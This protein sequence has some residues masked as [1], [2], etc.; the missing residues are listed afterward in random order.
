MV[1][2]PSTR[3]VL[4][5][6][7]TRIAKCQILLGTRQR[8]LEVVPKCL[9]SPGPLGYGRVRIGEVTSNT[10]RDKDIEASVAVEVCQ[11]G[12]PGPIGIGQASQA[13]SRN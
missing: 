2:P 6:K 5:L 1:E 3:N 13:A 4:K 10:I 7:V 9:P 11:F 12:C 8:G